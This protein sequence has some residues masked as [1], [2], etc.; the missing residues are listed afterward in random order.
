MTT[1]LFKGYLFSL[2]TSYPHLHSILI[3]MNNVR[4]IPLKIYCVFFVD[5]TEVMFFI[6]IGDY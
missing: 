2:F 5:F 1:S 3:P 6:H 4:D